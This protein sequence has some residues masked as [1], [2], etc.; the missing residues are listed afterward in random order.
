[1]NRFNQDISVLSVLAL[2]WCFGCSS[3]ER[4]TRSRDGGM[5]PIVLVA[6][7]STG[8]EARH[9][10]DFI[11]ASY[12][13]AFPGRKILWSYTSHIVRKKLAKQGILVESPEAIARSLRNE[14][15]TEAVFQSLH[16]APGQEFVEIRNM[17]I[18]RMQIRI[19]QPLLSSRTDIATVTAL[20][21][22][23]VPSDEVVVYVAH[24]NGA[25]PE[26]NREIIALQQQLE[27]IKKNGFVCTVEGDAPGLNGLAHARRL[28]GASGQI[29]FVPLMIVNGV[30]IRDDVLGDSTSSWKNIVAAS[31]NR[32]VPPLGER[33]EMI[34]L[35]I[36]HTRRALGM[37]AAT[38][39]A[40]RTKQKTPW[41]FAIS[42]V[43]LLL[44]LGLNIAAGVF[45]ANVLEVLGVIRYLAFITWP[46]TRMGRIDRS[47]S[48]AF[49]M[50]FQSGAVAN[51]ILAANRDNGM[52]DNRQLYCSVLVVSC[53]SLFAHLPTYVLPIG[54]VLG[55]GATAALFATRLAAIVLEVIVVLFF[56][57]GLVK[58]MEKRMNR[59]VAPAVPDLSSIQEIDGKEKK[60]A[61]SFA[62]QIWKR[63]GKTLLRLLV[64]VVPTFI[65]MGVVEY[66]GLF[67]H[68]NRMAP[69]LFS[70]DF[71]P[72]ESAMV[73][74]AQTISLYNGAIAAAGFVNSGAIDVK[75]AVFII[76]AG[77]IM[78]APVRTIKHAMPTYIAVL[79]VKAGTVLSISAQV[80]RMIFLTLAT[81]GLWFIW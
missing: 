62:K 16:V 35:F 49:L 10:Y 54:S 65:L 8:P 22:K 79:G 46:I 3:I 31:K 38:R 45:L 72:L 20:L 69:G 57:S 70:L 40:G 9:A 68:L 75:Q 13:K 43:K 44:K 2:L 78:T 4:K 77:S 50:A 37:P 18:P 11:D 80:L 71:L 81:I 66:F 21:A 63:S 56:G 58:L 53:L 1:M 33:P 34:D 7:G 6:F 23:A 55:V 17:K 61:S 28:A 32:L 60:T 52:I 26:Y 14:G 47:A 30:H 59:M 15:Y 42:K 41:A 29:T 36:Q 25:H 19:G 76:L 27:K 12:R 39:H 5:S 51:G 73:I 74:P 48:P 64:V 24:G 67:A